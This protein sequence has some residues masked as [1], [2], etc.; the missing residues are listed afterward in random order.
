MMII[1]TLNSIYLFAIWIIVGAT[2]GIFLGWWQW[3]SI[4][5][6]GN[7]NTDKIVNKLYII[8]A[9]RVLLVSGISFVAFLQGLRFGL[10]F[11]GAFFI[12][13]WCWTYFTIN[14]N[15]NIKE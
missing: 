15:K 13:R 7:E 1:N 10:S 8:L 2:T 4:R 11:L 14:K 5:K 9:I 12:S 6:L 3:I